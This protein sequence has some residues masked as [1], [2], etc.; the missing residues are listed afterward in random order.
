MKIQDDPEFI[1]GMLDAVY[2]DIDRARMFG[3][4]KNLAKFN[5]EKDVLLKKLKKAEKNNAKS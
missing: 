5:K 1:K 2:G 3:D 4:K